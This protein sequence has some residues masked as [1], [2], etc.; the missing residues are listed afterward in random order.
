MIADVRWSLF[1]RLI[2]GVLLLVVPLG[3]M[4]C[5]G[6]DGGTTNGATLKSISVSP[7][8]AKVTVGQTQ[9]F[10]VT[11]TYSDNKPRAITKGITWTSSSP[12]VATISTAG[13]ATAV[14]QGTTT[15]TAKIG[16]R[17]AT[18]TMTVPGEIS[19]TSIQVTPPSAS[20]G[21][22][23]SQSFMA[24]A[25]YNDGSSEDVTSSA[26]W[27]SSDT[28][29]ASVAA[30]VATAVA[31]GSATISASYQGET[32]SAALTVTGGEPTGLTVTPTP[33]SFAAGDSEQLTATLE[34]PDG[35]TQDVT[36]QAAWTSDDTAIVT[37]DATGLATGVAPGD[38]TVSVAFQGLTG[39]AEI[40][41]T[42]AYVTE[43]V[44]DPVSA[45]GVVGG[46]D[47]QFTATAIYSDL[48][49]SDVTDTATWTSSD[50]AIAAIDAA[51]A[52]TPLTGGTSTITAEFGGVEGT[53]TLTIDVGVFLT[54]V[55]VTP[56]TASIA[57]GT[58]Q[59]FTATATYSNNTT[60][61]VT[62]SVTWTTSAPA[63]ATIGSLGMATGVSAG[64]ATLTASLGTV[65]GTAAL[66]VTA[67]TLASIDVSP[68]TST[69]AVGGTQQYTATG[70]FTDSSTQDLTTVV[71]W[72]SSATATAAIDAAGLATGAA[73]GTTNITA[74]YQ[75]VTSNTAVL[76]VSGAVLTGVNV[77][78]T[79]VTIAAGTTAQ[80]TATAT[81]SDGT[82][83]NVTSAA[84]WTTSASAVATVSQLG[85]VTGVAAGAATIT[86]AYQGNSAPATITVSA[87]LMVSIQITP[88]APSI[89][90]GNTQQF[91]ATGLYSDNS[92]QDI[93]AQVTWTSA[94][95]AVA[96]ISNA[97]GSEGLATSVTAGTSNITAAFGGVTSN[98]AVLTVSG[99]ALTSIEVLP[100][101]P[102]VPAGFTQQFTV[103]GHYSDN[104]TAD[105]TNDL[106]V[107]FS[108][109]T[110]SVA[111]ISNAAGSK[112]LATT[113]AAGTTVITATRGALSG[114]TTLT[115]SAVTLSSIAVTPNT[116]TAQVGTTVQYTATGTF[117]DNSTANITSQCT[118]APT[119]GGVTVA[120]GG[121][122]T[123][124]GTA[125]PN[126][127]TITATRGA[128]Q[129]NA[130]LSVVQPLTLQAIEVRY[131][132]TEGDFV[133]NP[134]GFVWAMPESST[135][136]AVAV[137]IY[138]DGLNPPIEQDITAT[139]T[140]STDNGACLTASNAAATKGLLSST[141]D[142]PA[143][144]GAC[145][146]NI[147]ANLDGL[148]GTNYMNVTDPTLCPEDPNLF[149]AGTN[150]MFKG[151]QA[152]AV[153]FV[154]YGGVCGG[155][156]IA[157]EVTA[158]PDT[159]W[160]SSNTGVASVSSTGMVTASNNP[161]TPF[162]T[163]IT[164]THTRPG[165]TGTGSYLLQVNNACIQSIS[166][167]PLDPTIPQSL[168]L[169]LDVTANFSDG[170]TQVY[171]YMNLG[172]VSFTKVPGTSNAF[173][174]DGTTGIVT[175]SST[176]TG[177]A[178]VRVDVT[179]LACNPGNPPSATTSI[180]VS[181]ATITGVTVAPASASLSKSATTQLTATGTYSDGSSH[182]VTLIAN[183]G[184][185]NAPVA[186][187]GSTTATAGL[188]TASGTNEGNAVITATVGTFSGS[189]A[190]T[191]SGCT[192]NAIS[193]DLA[194]GFTCGG[195]P[196]GA[197]YPVGVNIPLVAT[198]SYAG[199]AAAGC[200]DADI[201]NQVTWS[202]DL[203][204]IAVASNGHARTNGSTGGT[205]A[206]ITAATGGFSGTIQLSAETQTLTDNLTVLPSNFSIPNGGVAQFTASG[207]F[208]SGACDLLGNVVTWGAAPST[209]L[210][211]N[212]T[213]RATAAATGAG[214]ATVTATYAPD[215]TKT[216]TVS[217]TVGGDCIESLYIT[218]TSSNLQVG[219]A[220]DFEARANLG[221][222]GTTDVDDTLVAWTIEA[223]AP[224]GILSS[225]GSGA[226]NALGVGTATI[227]GTW[228]SPTCSSPGSSVALSVTAPITITA[229]TLN[230]VV[231]ECVYAG[232]NILSHAGDQNIPVNVRGR[233]RAIGT[234]SDGTNLG[235]ISEDLD[236]SASGQA[237][238]SNVAGTK[239]AITGGVA[240]G[241]AII[242]VEQTGS[243]PLIFDE[244]ILTILPN[245][246][247]ASVAL[248]PDPMTLPVGYGAQY[249]ASG[250]YGAGLVFD[251]SNA[252]GAQWRCC[253]GTT[254]TCTTA[255]NCSV[256]GT[257]YITPTSGTPATVHPRID[258]GGETYHADLSISTQALSGITVN[259][260]GTPQGTAANMVLG[261][262]VQFQ[263]D[264]Y[265]GTG[266]SMI[267][268]FD[269]T[270]DV[271]WS[272]ST[273]GYISVSNSAG[274]KGLADATM[275]TPGGTTVT[276]LANNTTPAVQGTYA[277]LTVVN[278]C[279]DGIT[280]SAN[281]T[282]APAGLG[283]SF[284]VSASY[285][286][287]SSGT[288]T[289]Q[290]TNW[291]SDNAAAFST[292]TNCGGA[293]AGLPCVYY[294]G[295]PGQT[296]LIT[297]S[298]TGCGGATFTDS[299]LAS[300][301]SATLSS[302]DVTPVSTDLP[303]GQKTQFMATANYSNSTS[304]DV[305]A[306]PVFT[307]WNTADPTVAAIAA[308]DPPGTVLASI[309]NFGST[310]VIAT[311]HGVSDFGTVNVV[312]EVLTGITVYALNTIPSGTTCPNFDDMG[313]WGA[314]P[315]ISTG[316]QLPAGSYKSRVRAIGMYSDGSQ[317][318]ITA[319]VTWTSSVGGVATVVDGLVETGSTAGASTLTAAQ[320]GVSDTITLNTSGT[321]ISAVNV[322]PNGG[323]TRPLGATA[324][325]HVIGTF[326]AT[327]FCVDESATWSS[328][329]TSVATVSNLDN[330]RGWTTGVALGGTNITAT[331]GTFSD[332]EPFGVTSAV[333][334]YIAV[335]PAAVTINFTETAQ[336]VA[337]GHYSDG[338]D[339][340]ITT[341]A[342][343]NWSTT[344]GTY[345]EVNNGTNKG[346][347]TAY[348][349]GA[350]VETVDACVAAIC[351]S[352]GTLDRSAEVTVTP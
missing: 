154:E 63:I 323:F 200:P 76:A 64:T 155:L 97:A 100:A 85:L 41:V 59:Q 225:G 148:S 333:L 322:V 43:I 116:Q 228:S 221:S 242:R 162:T 273:A 110:A 327:S 216:G 279:V 179:A 243:S 13:L 78:C 309:S 69:I 349:I 131:R 318:D 141:A 176:N 72:T 238:V 163:T 135:L 319:N 315:W 347:F 21:V 214:N 70:V 68:A 10:A 133:A 182:D 138:S 311:Y 14:A 121:L 287:G 96:T 102:T 272:V 99:A 256:T 271:N 286:D 16:T 66:T 339:I 206:T 268:P 255:T 262:Q 11:G 184:S 87:A 267:G 150:P 292:P 312:D 189:S 247:L 205:Y 198:G 12:S 60:A 31:E 252:V 180:A 236:W 250:N 84:T 174:V 207:S 352:T 74:T 93:T 202:S 310:S 62:S 282:S 289:Q 280:L 264:G 48:T 281:T 233:C 27:S 147:Y 103:R 105:L 320:G 251:V 95:P 331:V 104:T 128:V 231:I 325:F 284:T 53:A 3:G 260:L 124:A 160:T 351:A 89:A 52:A 33:A 92:T 8:T 185:N 201:T 88:I 285:S 42:D 307:T 17:T 167:S 151:Q 290:V 197:A 226:F 161:P 19:L 350:G 175:A 340:D 191:V 18:A 1:T 217:G 239:G 263:A 328:A 82:T 209:L 178:N 245:A 193:V 222:G 181:S 293:T 79:P 51:G 301:N 346:L 130:T 86:A 305:T 296:S 125:A 215:N 249:S 77:T 134:Y 22:G 169:P 171:N 208:A 40:T 240:A 145:I 75:G 56:T 80:C 234:A 266:G 329:N 270:E 244:Q 308:G 101:N 157:W 277:G 45:M 276:I 212:A 199:G 257:G 112:G 122:A 298:F 35:S 165:Y 177:S 166:V 34:F 302:L 152:Q 129:G 90:L 156:G 26:T 28:A 114:T 140:W 139:A 55:E 168:E 300:V 335:M 190:I 261:E 2:L 183:W 274:T 306:D 211:I 4:A 46:G 220:V 71:S 336:L 344:P 232:S 345:G 137:G 67:A 338:S 288:I 254:A 9:Q 230:S 29:V 303:K 118:W 258:F 195:V 83:Q 25:M 326:G 54:S 186:T 241:S 283:V 37:V 158:S 196:A 324:R 159:V 106:A 153:A 213:G 94:T 108:S 192:L 113:L 172:P 314:A 15:I 294:A 98:T 229:A 337:M 127:Y 109:G 259:R 30:G 219:G 126:D 111:T 23:T 321:A 330:E 123:I 7:A 49:S 316:F 237:S 164:A 342:T 334:E 223:Q 6:D 210:T 246:D 119:T 348:N 317:R 91:A 269:I 146:A 248:Q 304:F 299:L 57:A 38:T 20:I 187:V 203:G 194:S 47:I 73:N 188:V 173:T 218:P 275:V 81:Y 253:T 144:A 65:Q 291:G 136:Q 107:S 295:T 5:G 142:V 341:G 115:V 149:I 39:A 265:F 227:K 224:Q 332:T 120:A 343:T 170:S 117:S 44:V 58:T 32:G 50:T 36:N 204:T 235:D 278:K 132:L 24:T 313:A 61:N 297:A 143:S